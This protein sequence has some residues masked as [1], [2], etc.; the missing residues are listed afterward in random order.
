MNIFIT[1]LIIAVPA[2]SAILI[3]MVLVKRKMEV[4]IGMK[5]ARIIEDPMD[6]EKLYRFTVENASDRAIVVI[7]VQL[8]SGGREIFDNGHHPSFKAPGSEGD[9][10]HIDS[11]RVRD[12]SDLLSKSF[13]GT[14]VMQPHEEMTYSY[15]MEESPDEI[16]ITVRENSDVEMILEPGFE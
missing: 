1:V 15:Y 14:T 13:L 5:D 11:K 7:A 3:Q 12:I 16:K 8:Y 9:V 6:D 4:E 10:V 2:L